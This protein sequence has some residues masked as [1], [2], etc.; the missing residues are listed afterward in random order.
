MFLSVRR[1]AASTSGNV[2]T[3]VIVPIADAALRLKQ[4]WTLLG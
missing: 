4:P 1:L 3:V 2:I